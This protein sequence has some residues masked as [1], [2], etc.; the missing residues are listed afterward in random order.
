MLIVVVYVF[1]VFI[2]VHVFVYTQTLVD[3]GDLS[4]RIARHLSALVDMYSCCFSFC[5]LFLL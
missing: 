2:S 4:V 1:D 5:L 3:I